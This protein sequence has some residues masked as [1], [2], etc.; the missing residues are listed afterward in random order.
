MAWCWHNRASV[1]VITCGAE[2]GRA[3]RIDPQRAHKNRLQANAVRTRNATIAYRKL[4][5][6]R[7]RNYA[8]TDTESRP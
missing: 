6:N 4:D 7:H 3:I 2:Q 8:A 1:S 5:R